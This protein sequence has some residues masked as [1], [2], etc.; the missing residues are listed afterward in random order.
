MF[1]EKWENKAQ[2]A[3]NTSMGILSTLSTLSIFSTLSTTAHQ[4]HSK[5]SM[6][7]CPDYFHREN[8]SFFALKKTGY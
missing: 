8:G 6:L 4:A 1:N 7:D 5:M 3:N 2:Q